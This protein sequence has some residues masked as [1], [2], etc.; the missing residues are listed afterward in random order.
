M[1]LTPRVSTRQLNKGTGPLDSLRDHPRFQALLEEVQGGCG[2]LAAKPF[3]FR[4]SGKVWECSL[5][6]TGR[7]TP[8]N[9]KTYGQTPRS[10][11][12]WAKLK[13]GKTVRTLDP[14]TWRK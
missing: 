7:I 13:G 1:Q 2:A 8:S 3:R 10:I 14:L 4:S 12:Y 5:I 9:G 6:G 11:A